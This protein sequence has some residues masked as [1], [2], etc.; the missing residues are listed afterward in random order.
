ML[1]WQ[2]D[3]D[4]SKYDLSGWGEDESKESKDKETNKD[5]KDEETSKER[6][7]Q[8]RRGK[9]ETRE[10]SKSRSRS[11]S[12][13][14]KRSRNNHSDSRSVCF[15]ASVTSCSYHMQGQPKTRRHPGQ[16]INFAPFKTGTPQTFS[17]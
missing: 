8:D 14:Y 16:T 2:E 17:A 6:K 1:S 13:S 7:E 11:R 5:I 3:E 15:Y 9:N 10:H 12:P 4:L